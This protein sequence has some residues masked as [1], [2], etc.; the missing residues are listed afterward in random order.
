MLILLFENT[1]ATKNAVIDIHDTYGTRKEIKQDFLQNNI[2]TIESDNLL[3]DIEDNTS[4]I[5]DVDVED[6]PSET[7]ITKKENDGANT[8]E[9]ITE[10]RS[11]KYSLSALYL[12]E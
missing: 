10:S 6:V 12:E 11:D 4:K 8:N 1:N 3:S 7:N 9:I 2:Y 5:S